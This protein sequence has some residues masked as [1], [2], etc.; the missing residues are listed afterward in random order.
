MAIEPTGDIYST[1]LSEKRRRT[2]PNGAVRAAASATVSCTNSRG[3]IA[4]RRGAVDNT[5]M[6]LPMW[7]NVFLAAGAISL[8]VIRD[9]PVMRDRRRRDGS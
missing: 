3:T 6:R 4:R 8:S 9:S 2:A 1:G 5:L 7:A